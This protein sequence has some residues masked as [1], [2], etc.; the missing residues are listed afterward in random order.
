M[1]PLSALGVAASV[2]SVVGM[3]ASCLKLCSKIMGL[4]PSQHTS[5]DLKSISDMLYQFNGSIKNL[6]THLELCEEDQARLSAL[7]ELKTPLADCEVALKVLQDH[8]KGPRLGR[9]LV[10]AGFDSKIKRSL[11]A[12]EHSRALFVET[13][14]A[15]QQTIVSAVERYVR[16]NGEDLRELKKLVQHSSSGI[17]DLKEQGQRNHEEEIGLYK[18]MQR[19]QED[20]FS[21][22][23]SWIDQ[24]N[25]RRQKS[26]D[27]ELIRW[28]SA[29]DSEVKQNDTLSQ[30][31]PHTGGW[32]FEASDFKDWVA[33]PP[34]SL[35]CPGMP[36]AGK[37]VVAAVVVDHLRKTLNTSETPVACIYCNYK[38]QESQ[39]T[40]A[41][42][43]SILQQLLLVQPTI[44]E[45]IRD[46]HHQHTLKSTRPSLKDVSA[47]LSSQVRTFKKLF[48]VVEALDE[49]SVSN[50]TRESLLDEL[51][52]LQP[53]VH[54]FV[55]SR[56]SVGALNVS[57]DALVIEIRAD[58]LD[59]S[60]YCA[61]RLREERRLAT[62][63]RTDL[64][65]QEEITRTLVSNAQGM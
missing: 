29:L 55:T 15:D 7:K 41:I 6:Q 47:M 17:L 36:G 40:L 32:I 19:V 20:I 21:H 35:W 43:E 64:N 25:E 50:P 27:N 4:G 14:R 18:K 1:D 28:L 60:T 5:D 30:R 22:G 59:V 51:R 16:N 10:G 37:T 44:P 33:G 39:T 45:M 11:N 48:V 65:L 12:L 3:T 53:Y 31:Y 13:L 26:E 2:I 49:L 34:R 8:L 58:E 61:A 38:Q 42:L 52:A 9:Y 54:L 56:P 62:W 57:E 24:G 23:K 46:F 63:V